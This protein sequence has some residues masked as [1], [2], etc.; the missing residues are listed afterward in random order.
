MSFGVASLIISDS[1]N[2]LFYA[3]IVFSADFTNKYRAK[4]G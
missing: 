3:A 4:Q 2:I 1:A